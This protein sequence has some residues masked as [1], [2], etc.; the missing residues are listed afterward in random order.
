MPGQKPVSTL[1]PLTMLIS[2]LSSPD[3]DS[4]DPSIVFEIVNATGF[5]SSDEPSTSGYSTVTHAGLRSFAAVTSIQ[6]SNPF[7]VDKNPEVAYHPPTVEDEEEQ[8]KQHHSTGKDS[9]G[10]APPKSR[11]SPQRDSQNTPKNA[12][13]SEFIVE[14]DPVGLKYSRSTANFDQQRAEKNT[15]EPGRWAEDIRAGTTTRAALSDE[16]N[17]EI[18]ST[19][20]SILSDA[21][22]SRASMDGDWPFEA[23]TRAVAIPSRSTIASYD[24]V[25]NQHEQ[26]KPPRRVFYVDEGGYIAR[27]PSAVSGYG[28]IITIKSPDYRRTLKEDETRER[29]TAQNAKRKTEREMLSL[30]RLVAE[31]MDDADFSGPKQSSSAQ[32]PS[33]AS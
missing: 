29:Q 23:A 32:P 20:S 28:D 27:H 2:N 16:L 24:P 25:L 3:F 21:Y 22:Y 17:G 33:K 13:D 1:Q 10:P 9:P 19:T 12:E 26:A 7:Y 5:G 11:L 31:W 4:S 14:K 15:E 30:T 6:L 18:S 8:T